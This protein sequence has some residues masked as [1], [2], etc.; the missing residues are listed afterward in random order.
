MTGGSLTTSIYYRMQ[1]EIDEY[2]STLRDS[3][4]IG[5]PN[6]IVDGND[7]EGVI[8]KLFLLFDQREH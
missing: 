8:E 3:V 6:T 2:L 4:T 1:K 7:L 5:T